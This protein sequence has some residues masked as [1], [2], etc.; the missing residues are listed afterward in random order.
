MLDSMKAYKY[1]VM[2]MSVLAGL[3]GGAQ[4]AERH[5][6]GDLVVWEAE[7]SRESSDA[8][9]ME[10]GNA[11]AGMAEE[12]P[13]ASLEEGDSDASLEEENADAGMVDGIADAGMEEEATDADIVEGDSDAGM[14]EGTAVAE[15]PDAG[16]IPLPEKQVSRCDQ[17]KILH[18][19][20]RRND[21]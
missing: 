13:D 12:A 8:A 5:Y 2:L 11:D 19:N 10:E 17:K 21:I 18:K 20:G 9:G 7:S 3:A 4:A 16:E 14:E 1:M 15:Q 6:A